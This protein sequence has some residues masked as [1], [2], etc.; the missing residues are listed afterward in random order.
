MHE[1]PAERP[2][3]RRRR[4]RN[5]SAKHETREQHQ[6]DELDSGLPALVRHRGRSSSQSRAKSIGLAQS[7]TIWSA[8]EMGTVWRGRVSGC[9]SP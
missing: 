5:E 9:S 8:P 3:V 4:E 1:E 7:F 2:R 6:C